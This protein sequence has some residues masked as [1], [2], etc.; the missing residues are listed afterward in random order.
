MRIA[1]KFALILT[2][3]VVLLVASIS[4]Y[5]IRSERRKLIADMERQSVM[6]T[7]TIA[8]GVN[9]A[10]FLERRDLLIDYFDQLVPKSDGEILYTIITGLDGFVWL[11]TMKAVEYETLNDFGDKEL[12]KRLK[13]EKLVVRN[14]DHPRLSEEVMEVSTPIAVNQMERAILRIGFSMQPL[15]ARIHRAMWNSVVIGLAALVA[16]VL[17]SLYLAKGVAQPIKRVVDYARAVSEGE[18]SETLTK[19]SSTLEMTELTESIERMKRDLKY[20]YIGGLFRDF[21]HTI[22]SDLGYL[23]SELER[24][25]HDQKDVQGMLL[26]LDRITAEIQ[27]YKSL[28]KPMDLKK[29]TIESSRFLNRLVASLPQE[30]RRQIEVEIPEKL[31]HVRGD[32]MYLGQAIFHILKNAREASSGEDKVEFKADQKN[33]NLFVE[34]T[35]KG[36][37]IPAEQMERVFDPGFTT[38][39][40][41]GGEGLGLALSQMIVEDLHDGELT[42]KSEEGEGTRVTIALQ[43]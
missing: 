39:E 28:N 11:D 18:L 31:P 37:G 43:V 4:F 26:R 13:N 2:G 5:L 1:S 24:L 15:N 7:E 12:L 19:E 27:K 22:K 3:V 33:G 32:P 8:L 34:V 21:S 16:G 17:L 9:S 41:R 10:T 35:D 20:I 40:K 38:K 36:C 14:F 23:Y 25:R 6:T 42:I 30:E 29:V